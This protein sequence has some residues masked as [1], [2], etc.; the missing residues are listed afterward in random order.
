MFIDKVQDCLENSVGEIT[1]IFNDYLVLI[2]YSTKAA[3]EMIDKYNQG[4]SLSLNDI[5]SATPEEIKRYEIEKNID[6]YNI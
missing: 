3:N 4:M 1:D 6:K 5:R 2:K